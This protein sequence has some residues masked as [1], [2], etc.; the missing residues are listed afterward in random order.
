MLEL[1][2]I[3]HGK[4]GRQDLYDFTVFTLSEG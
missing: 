3:F 4:A 2:K 1:H